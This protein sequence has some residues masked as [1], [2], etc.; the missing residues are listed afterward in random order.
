MWSFCYFV[1]LFAPSSVQLTKKKKKKKQKKNQKNR[2]VVRNSET[3]AGAIDPA[4]GS[5]RCSVKTSRGSEVI[6][7][8]ETRQSFTFFAY[9]HV[10]HDLCVK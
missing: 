7:G 4:D 3:L 9:L 10:I 1:L 6:N 2:K 5:I 8:E